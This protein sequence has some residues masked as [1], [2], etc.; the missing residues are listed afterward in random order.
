MVTL[1]ISQ[2]AVDSNYEP[3]KKMGCLDRESGNSLGYIHYYPL[4]NFLLTNSSSVSLTNIDI[5]G[6]KVVDCQRKG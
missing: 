3:F 1:I 5:S 2:C 4:D 6:W